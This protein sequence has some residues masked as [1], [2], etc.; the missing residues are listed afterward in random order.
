MSVITISA[1]YG[2]GGAVIGPDLGRRLGAPFVDRAIPAEVAERLSVPLEQA[3]AH[4]ESLGSGLGRVLASFAVLTDLYAPQRRLETLGEADYRRE[5]ER[6]LLKAASSG[7]AI[8]L[9]RAGA[10]VLNEH[11]GTLHVRLD[12]P[13]ERRVAQ[14]IRLSQIDE[15]EARR[16]LH[17]TD[18]AREAYVRHF[19]GVNANDPALYHLVIDSTVIGLDT[20]AG[21]I[22]DAAEAITAGSPP[23]GE[24]LP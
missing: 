22:A 16:G 9:G 6:V 1:S 21:L 24:G 12:G 15:P 20:C 13:A 7:H 3:L 10:L 5:T 19:Y 23:G 2:A 8:I 14:A 18:R 11:P 4:D 17:Q